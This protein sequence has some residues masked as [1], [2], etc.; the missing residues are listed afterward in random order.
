MTTTSYTR[1]STT[2]TDVT[3]DLRLARPQPKAR[4]GLRATDRH[5][6]RHGRPQHHP[7]AYP[8]SGKPLISNRK[9]SDGH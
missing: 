2:L 4:Q 6:H 1:N 5:E 8:L 7:A 9:F 3:A